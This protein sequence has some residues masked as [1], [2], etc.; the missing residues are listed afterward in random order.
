MYC[1]GNHY[2]VFCTL[3]RGGTSKG[4]ILRTIDLPTRSEQRDRLILRLFGSPDQNQIDGL[5]GGTSLTSKVALVG[6]S[7][8]SEADIS[9]TFGQVSLDKEVIDYAPT[10]G[11]MATAVGLYAVEEGYV[12][13]TEPVTYVRIFNTNIKRIIVAE[14]PVSG[15]QVQYE[16][17]FSIAGV[18]GSSARIML[19]FPHSEGAF[20]GH[21]LPTGQPTDR[22]E[23]SYGRSYEVSI[24]DAANVVVFIKAEDVGLTGCELK[25]DIDR[26]NGSIGIIEEIR[27]AAGRKIGLID[28]EQEVSPSSHALPK[29]VF[30]ASPQDYVTANGHSISRDDC[31]ILARYISMGSLHKA[32]AV[33]GAVALAAASKIEGTIP[34]Q[35]LSANASKTSL[36]IGHPSGLLYVE[37]NIKRAGS[38]YQ[39]L[40]SAIGR[41]AR[42]LMDGYAY[43]PISVLKRNEVVAQQ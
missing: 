37:A 35:A 36:S 14:I 10:C 15:G 38:G 27:V 11:N 40:R 2:R 1:I 3:M 19:D 41:T 12:E 42:R 21:L 32:F 29:I 23:L 5:G 16:G 6:P 43:I 25:E 34:N 20:T 31:D 24:I 33:S 18:P 22:I 7:H 13:M 17:D 28:K 39:V 4:A 8:F 9:Y 30:V 26:V